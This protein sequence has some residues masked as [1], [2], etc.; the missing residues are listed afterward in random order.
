MD[1]HDRFTLPSSSLPCFYSSCRWSI[2]EDFLREHQ[3]GLSEQ[4]F[5]GWM[6]DQLVIRRCQYGD[7]H[8][9]SDSALRRRAPRGRTL[10]DLG[11]GL[12]LCDN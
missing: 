8:A 4:A 1:Q 12:E 9:G 7:F 2:Y 5:G 6:R 10:V 11:H 3:Y